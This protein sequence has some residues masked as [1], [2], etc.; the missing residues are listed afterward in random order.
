MQEFKVSHPE[1]LRPSYEDN[2]DDIRLLVFI[3]YHLLTELTFKPINHKN[4]SVKVSN[5]NHRTCKTSDKLNFIKTENHENP[6]LM[7][8]ITHCLFGLWITRRNA[9]IVATAHTDH[10]IA[11]V[12]TS[13]HSM[14]RFNYRKHTR[15]KCT[16]TICITKKMFTLATRPDSV[17]SSSVDNVSLQREREK[18]RTPENM[19]KNGPHN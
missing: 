6:I 14:R 13:C 1:I 16:S 4:I 3:H 12:V 10:T 7:T 8:L 15:C 5:Q 17:P 2:S 9:R 18:Q 19:A 11:N